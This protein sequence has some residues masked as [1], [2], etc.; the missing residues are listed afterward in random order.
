M[1][2][3][4]NPQGHSQEV[5]ADLQRWHSASEGPPQ[6]MVILAYPSKIGVPT[7]S[8]ATSAT[9][10]TIDRATTTALAAAPSVFTS[11]DP[12]RS[13]LRRLP[14]R[15]T[16]RTFSQTVVRSD[17]RSAERESYRGEGATV[18]SS[19]A[20]SRTREQLLQRA[21]GIC[22]GKVKLLRNPD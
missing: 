21:S 11:P 17:G 13:T 22:S 20:A 9:G 6:S 4:V 19:A 14:T 10:H 18:A 3:Q 12:Q 8:P 5:L 16:A 15:D 2:L 7:H 1:Y